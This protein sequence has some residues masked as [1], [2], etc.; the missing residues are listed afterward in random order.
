MDRKTPRV[1][2]RRSRRGRF[3]Q[4]EIVVIEMGLGGSKFEHANRL[5]VGQ[6]GTFV[7]GP[8]STPAVVRHSVMLPTADGFVYQSGVAFTD[9]GPTEESLLYELLVQ[10]ARE[11]VVEWESNLAGETPPAVRASSVRSAVAPRYIKLR[12]QAGMWKRTITADP[13]Q[14]EDGVTIID[15]TPE[16]EEEMLKKTYAEG[17]Q[18]ARELLHRM[19]TVAILEKLRG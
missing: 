2:L 5:T 16:A 8:L 10:E 17:D 7:C 15:S 6:T 18:A 14:P 3:E 1:V 13:N 19:A 12:F 9:V 11:Q 4:A